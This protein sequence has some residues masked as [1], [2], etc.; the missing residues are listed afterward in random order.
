MLYSVVQKINTIGLAIIALIFV[1]CNKDFNPL[2]SSKDDIIKILPKRNI[3]AYSKCQSMSPF[4][5]EL[6]IA[7]PEFSP[8]KLS[9]NAYRSVFSHDGKKIAFYRYD[10]KENVW[11][12]NLY[13]IDLV[14]GYIQKC[15][16]I[17]SA[18]FSTSSYFL[19]NGFYYLNHFDYFG[20]K[21]LNN[22]SL[23]PIYDVK[24]SYDDTN[25]AYSKINSDSNDIY[26]FNI[27]DNSERRLTKTGYSRN[28]YWSHDD[29]KIA[30]KTLVNGEQ[31]LAIAHTNNSNIQIVDLP[32]EIYFPRWLVDGRIVIESESYESPGYHDIFLID[33]I[34]NYS[35][36]THDI[37]LS[38]VNIYDENNLILNSIY[39]SDS[40]QFKILNMNSME[41]TP[42]FK[43]KQYITANISRDKNWIAYLLRKPDH[44]WCL[45][46]LKDLYYYNDILLDDEVID[47]SISWSN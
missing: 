41:I 40:L 38:L 29:I 23:Y 43:M 46:Y 44:D 4:I 35:R 19:R 17:N 14:T 47:W 39:H 31:E 10:I 28:P 6:W 9:D 18:I 45:L 20:R 3:I 5:V 1:D 2:S 30:L 15:A 37:N 26:I 32:G 27:T 12:D 25:L 42:W 36:I 7:G 13:Y 8:R 33:N 11:Q 21:N 22:F 16:T 34:F 24:W